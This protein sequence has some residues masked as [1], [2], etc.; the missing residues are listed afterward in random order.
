MP[1]IG[2]RALGVNLDPIK[3]LTIKEIYGT[4]IVSVPECNKRFWKLIKQKNLKVKLQVS[5]GKKSPNV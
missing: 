5:G 1:R 3:D 2:L 4:G